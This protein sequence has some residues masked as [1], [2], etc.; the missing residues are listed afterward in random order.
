[1]KYYI[2][3]ITGLISILDV[4]IEKVVYEWFI[5]IEQLRKS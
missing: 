3:D 5:F 4:G 1:M 2:S